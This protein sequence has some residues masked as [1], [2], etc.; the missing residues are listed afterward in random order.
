MED[1]KTKLS[2]KS[3]LYFIN[4][5]VLCLLAISFIIICAL[6]L[7]SYNYIENPYK[8]PPYLF[9]LYVGRVLIVIQVLFTLLSLI[10]YFLSGTS[11]ALNEENLLLEDIEEGI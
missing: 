7:S 11:D 10:I 5:T 6:F 8:I 2:G 4:A 9:I 3:K 1:N